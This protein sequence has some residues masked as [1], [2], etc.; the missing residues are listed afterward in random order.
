VV[1][2]IEFRAHNAEVRAGRVIVVE[3]PPKCSEHKLALELVRVEISQDKVV[4]DVY[5]CPYTG[6][7][8]EHYSQ[9]ARRTVESG[10]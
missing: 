7:K 8:T 9:Q 3:A 6:C 10:K 1:E 2:E 5:R 4:T